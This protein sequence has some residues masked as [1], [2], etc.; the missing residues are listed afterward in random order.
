M[1]AEEN[2]ANKFHFWK[3]VSIF[4]FFFLFSLFV[5]VGFYFQNPAARE[6]QDFGQHFLLNL[7]IWLPWALLAFIVIWLGRKFP[8]TTRTWKYIIPAHVAV[9]ISL[10]FV[11][12]GMVGGMFMLAERLLILNQEFSI[13]TIF[14]KVFYLD[15]ITYGILLGG[16]HLFNLNRKIRSLERKIPPL[17]TRLLQ[18]QIKSWER[19]LRPHFILNIMN[20][21]SMTLLRDP[22]AADRMISRLN[23]LLRLDFENAS[24]WEVP[25]KQELGYIKRY[26]EI[27]EARFPDKLKIE[28]QVPEDVQEALVPKFIL[29]PLV[30][31][32]IFHGIVPQK[33]GGKI[34]I[35][36]YRKYR[37]MVIQIY[38]SGVGL[39]QK[40]E[41]LIM[42][43]KSL[44][45]ICERLKL[46]YGEGY[47]F[48]LENH[49][50]KGAVAVLEI[51]FHRNPMEQFLFQK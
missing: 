40:Q 6:T 35:G 30:E 1:A 3:I 11:H 22:L 18:M 44:G 47:N 4:V 5:S 29:P 23:D 38:D 49:E 25:L 21:I 33:E 48:Q 32:A 37:I 20:V 7:N 8:I 19:Q 42:S 51:P 36:A 24:R 43:G 31:N 34:E 27:M 46:L 9:S 15:I 39:N 28:F 45:C 2:R 26:L 41:E 14:P 16:G 17:E 50:K 10:A 12:T 13:K